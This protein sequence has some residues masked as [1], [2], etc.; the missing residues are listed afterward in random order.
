MLKDTHVKFN[1]GL[2]VN[3]PSN[4]RAQTEKNRTWIKEDK[5]LITR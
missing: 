5:N 1:T 3:R 4:N 2:R